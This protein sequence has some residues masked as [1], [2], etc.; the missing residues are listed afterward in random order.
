[1]VDPNGKVVK[2]TKPKEEAVAENSGF[3]AGDFALDDFDTDFTME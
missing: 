3:D 2:E 1:M